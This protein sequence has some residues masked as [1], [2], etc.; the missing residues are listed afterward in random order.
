[1]YLITV[2]ASRMVTSNFESLSV[3]CLWRQEEALMK[4]FNVR[5][6]H[7]FC[8]FFLRGSNSVLS[9]SLFEYHFSPFWP[10]PRCSHA[11]YSNKNAFQS[12]WVITLRNTFATCAMIISFYNKTYTQD[13]RLK[14]DWENNRLH[15]FSNRPTMNGYFFFLV[16]YERFYFGHISQP[17]C[18]IIREG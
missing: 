4:S 5:K 6:W 3:P 1:M 16:K 18:H 10:S 7:C 12:G 13:Q 11:N 2:V 17:S 14:Q 9:Y 8:L 15:S